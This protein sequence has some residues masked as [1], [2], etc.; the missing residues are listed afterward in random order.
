MVHA[1]DHNNTRLDVDE[2]VRTALKK[3]IHTNR[4]YN[5]TYLINDI[6]AVNLLEP[7]VLNGKFKGIY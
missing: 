6:A 1:G 5:L 7:F 3:E 2:Q 4:D